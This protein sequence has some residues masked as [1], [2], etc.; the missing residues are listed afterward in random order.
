MTPYVSYFLSLICAILIFGTQPTFATAG[1][2]VFV[3]IQPQKYFVEQIGQGRVQVH[4][5]VAPGASPATYEPKPH[6][7]IALSQAVLYF[8]IG[9]PFEKVWL[10][11]ISAANPGMRIVPTD[12]DIAKHPMPD[13]DHLFGGDSASHHQGQPDPHIWLSP[14]LV[15]IQ[16]RHVLTALCQFDPEHTPVYEANYKKFIQMLDQLDAELREVFKDHQDLAFMVFHPSWGYFA[17][18]YG[19][20][21]LP[22]EM[23][24]KQ[25]KPAQMR[26][27]IKYARAHA[28]KIIFVQP[29]FSTRSAQAIAEAI[30]GQLVIA[31]PLAYDWPGNLRQ[32]ALQ[33]KAA[34]R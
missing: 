7:M 3:S 21:Q 34:L 5:M 13:F 1:H 30:N 32:Q 14:P 9:V 12:R 17:Q 25:P 11:K 27:L 19:L 33:I 29:Q 20:K 10:A 24:G 2:Q 18:T 28:V 8:A 22:V 23:E 31:D 6:Q 16:A 15:K 26:E 4:V